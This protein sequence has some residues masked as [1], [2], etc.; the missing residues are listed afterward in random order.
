MKYMNMSRYAQKIFKNARFKAAPDGGDGGDAGS[1]DDGVAGGG[2]GSS[3]ADDKG[4]ADEPSI[5]DLKIQLAKAQAQAD[6]YKNSIDNLTKKNGELTKQ[7]RQYM[8]D[9]ERA[10]AD[11]EERDRELAEL[12]AQV[13]IADYSKWFVGMG[14][15]AD[16]ADAM[17]A[18]IPELEDADAFFAGLSK[19]VESVRKASAES[20]VQELLKNRPDINA[21]NGESSTSIAEEKAVALAKSRGG[22]NG[23]EIA[24]NYRMK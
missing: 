24:D 16:E 14:L 6:R 5:E 22:A 3:A 11:Q 21:G 23:N 17:A 12:K 15:A 1:G 10:K 8:N 19:Y 18:T 13:R 4:G 20:A 9:E 7:N 2:G